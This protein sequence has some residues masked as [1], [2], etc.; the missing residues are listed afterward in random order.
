MA[1]LILGFR[2]NI[3][4]DNVALIHP[5]TQLLGINRFQVI[6]IAEVIRDNPLNLRDLRVTKVTDRVPPDQRSVVGHGIASIEPI[7]AHHHQPSR[8]EDVQML[9]CIR[10]AQSG[11]LSQVLHR[12]LSLGQKFQEFQAPATGERLADHC[13]LIEERVLEGALCGASAIQCCY[14]AIERREWSTSPNKAESK[15]TKVTLRSAKKWMVEE[16]IS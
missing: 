14:A 15:N 5:P 11:L 13:E 7:L 4:K 8:T 2:T 10:N 16:K 3:E 12:S 6:P 9:R 1:C